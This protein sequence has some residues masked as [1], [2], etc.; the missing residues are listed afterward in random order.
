MVPTQSAG[1]KLTIAGRSNRSPLAP[2]IYEHIWRPRALTI[3]TGQKFP[4]EREWALVCEWLKPSRGALIL[5]LGS[6]TDGYARALGRND[7]TARIVAV[8]TA[9]NMLRAGRGYARR[10]GITNIAH[11]CAPVERLPFADA[12]VDALVCGGSLNEFR[13][14]ATALCEARRVCKPQGRMLAMSL[15]AASSW[16]GKLAQLAARASG[17]QFPRLDEFNAIV[18]GASWEVERQEIFGVAVFSLL[19]RA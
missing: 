1:V 6:S 14:M 11:L 2:Q 16:K 15:L 17:I 18:R 8:D 4:L 12:T 5:D 13:S 7:P 10:E 9:L 3:L 19:R